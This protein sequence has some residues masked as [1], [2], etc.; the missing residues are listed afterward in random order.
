MFQKRG[1]Q[2]TKPRTKPGFTGTF[3]YAS[4]FNTHVRERE[5]AV[6]LKKKKKENQKEHVNKITA[7][8][9]AVRP[10]KTK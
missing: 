4:Q 8:G 1:K 7:P 9:A 2:E 10:P 5:R 3:I 6:M